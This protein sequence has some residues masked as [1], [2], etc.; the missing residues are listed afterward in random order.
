M[1]NLSLGVYVQAG[2]CLPK[3]SAL[4]QFID[5]ISSL[6]YK[7]LYLGIGENFHVQKQPYLAYMI[8]RYTM[9]DIQDLDKYAQGVG[10]Q[11]IPAI[12]TLAHYHTIPC[13]AHYKPIMDHGHVLLADDEKTYAFL[14]DIFEAVAEAFSTKRIMIGMD[15]AHMLGAGRYYDIHGNVDR[16]QILLLHLQKVLSIAGQYG[17]SCE[18]WSDM[19]FKLQS[20]DNYSDDNML[21]PKELLGQLPNDLKIVHWNYEVMDVDN[22]RRILQEHKKMTSNVAMTGGFYKWVGFAPNNT[23]SIQANRNLIQAVQAENIQELNLAMWCDNGGE[24]SVFSI[25]PALFDAAVFAGVTDK[26]EA[27]KLFEQ[28]TGMSKEE[29]RLADY[30]NYPHFQEIERVGNSC[31]YLLYADPLLSTFHSLVKDDLKEAYAKYAERVKLCQKGKFA[32]IFETYYTLAK[33]LED[34]ASL[35]V[36][37]KDAYTIGNRDKL[38]DIATKTIPQLLENIDVFFT[39]FEKQWHMENSSIGFEIHCARIGALRFRVQYVANVLLRYCEQKI[40]R[41][42]ELEEETLPFA[43]MEGATAD[44]Y[45]LMCWNN[46]ITSG[47]NW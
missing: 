13:Y 17:Y 30:L 34:K 38:Y 29:F 27:E 1:S 35:G 6:G 36:E 45:Q 46:I 19:F 33:V 9:S 15:E 47:I 18:M 24:A 8:G 32:Y 31:F 11:L 2:D 20:M 14:N 23:Y 4:K 25:L 22:H 43:Y 39:A 37:I 10:M 28:Y 5:V 26:K 3:L 21:A 44:N 40:D 7:R 41:I 12:Q 16:T 42:E